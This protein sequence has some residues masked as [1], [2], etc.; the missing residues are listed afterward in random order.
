M[1]RHTAV[2]PPTLSPAR[3]FSH[4]VVAALG[5]TVYLGGQTAQGPDGSIVGVTL[6]EQFDRA[7]AN[8]SAAL[9]AVGAQP[10][11]LVSLTIYVTNAAAYRADLAEL[12]ARYRRHL[13][14]HYPAM[15][16]FEVRGL[17]DP[18]AL[19]EL[20]GT[21]VLPPLEAQEEVATPAT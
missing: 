4:A 6:P 5:R 1:S 10:D 9:R 12:G 8:L 18:Q 7:L 15:A 17:F 16:F 14:R 2:N 20:V 13:G 21:A 3:G 11:D 19:V